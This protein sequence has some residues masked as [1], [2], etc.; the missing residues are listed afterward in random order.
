VFGGAG[1]A[2]VGVMFITTCI[3]T[4]VMLVVWNMHVL[5]YTTLHSV[6]CYL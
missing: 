2:V 1:V 4:L 3:V 6:F 5:S